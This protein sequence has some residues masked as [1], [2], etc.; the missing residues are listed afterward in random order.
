MSNASNL[1]IERAIYHLFTG[2]D[3][4][5]AKVDLGQFPSDIKPGLNVAVTSGSFSLANMDEY[6]QDVSIT[7]LIAV[8]NNRSEFERRRLAHPLCEYAI[9]TLVTSKLVLVG[10]GLTPM[11]VDGIPQLLDLEDL[12]PVSWR[13]T[14]TP[15]NFKAGETTFEAHF[16]TS[17]RMSSEPPDAS[18]VH[19]LDEI[20]STWKMS[21]GATPTVQGATLIDLKGT[22]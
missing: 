11:L 10:E 21:D 12:A 2:P 6:S 22:P 20:L 14:T 4:K 16:K 1:D 5:F 3:R 8:K 13:E 7:L 15:D 18:E 17:T 19:D 9:R